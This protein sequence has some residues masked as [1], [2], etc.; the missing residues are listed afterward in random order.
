MAD[1]WHGYTC[2]RRDVVAAGAAEGFAA[3]ASPPRARGGGVRGAAARGEGMAAR[4]RGDTRERRD[5]TATM[6]AGASCAVAHWR[7][8]GGALRGRVHDGVWARRDRA[9]TLSRMVL[10]VVSRTASAWR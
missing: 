6:A 5:V 9:A 7:R 1:R 2:Q 4:W 10:P 8:E 3:I